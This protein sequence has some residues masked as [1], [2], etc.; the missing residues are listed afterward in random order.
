MISWR[1]SSS[2]ARISSAFALPA[3]VVESASIW[4]PL[5]PLVE[6]SLFLLFK[7]ITQ[8]ARM[9]CVGRDI[10]SIGSSHNWIIPEE[11]KMSIY[12]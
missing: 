3:V 2:K 1:V 4:L 8:R 10:V 12:P 11:A 6:Q 7:T 5:L 9:K